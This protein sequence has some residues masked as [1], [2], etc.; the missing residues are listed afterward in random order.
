MWLAAR[1]ASSALSSSALMSSSALT[2]PALQAVAC[3]AASVFLE[4]V[5][6]GRQ[7]GRAQLERE[8]GLLHRF[9]TGVMPVLDFTPNR[10]VGIR[11]AL[12]V[13]IEDQGAS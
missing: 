4:G 1:S 7:L 6:R 5:T 9:H 8:L 12:I 2:R 11:G 3:A 13:G 10:H